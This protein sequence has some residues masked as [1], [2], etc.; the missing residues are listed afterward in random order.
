M[1]K[2][3]KKKLLT[4][5]PGIPHCK[6]KK[7]PVMMEMKYRQQNKLE[8]MDPGLPLSEATRS[9]TSVAVSQ[10]KLAAAS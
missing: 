6:V 9:W 2:K 7:A 5:L 3:K 8:G 4:Q 10:L 1:Q